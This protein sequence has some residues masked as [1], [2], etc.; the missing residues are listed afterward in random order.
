MPFRGGGMSLGM[1]SR[2]SK[3]AGYWA[4][5][6]VLRF[7]NSLPGRLYPCC[8]AGWVP[9]W[10]RRNWSFGFGLGRGWWR[11]PYAYPMSREEELD[12][13]KKESEAIR[14][15]LEEIDARIKELEQA[16]VANHCELE[17]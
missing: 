1:G 15:E 16:N 9:A 17:G 13:L 10:S 6:G 8:Y 4:N 2:S 11:F 5:F 3:A 14:K 12:L 7:A